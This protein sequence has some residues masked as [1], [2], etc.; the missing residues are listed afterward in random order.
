ME[1]A[2]KL[3]PAVLDVNAVGVPD[4]RLGEAVTLVV[5]PRPGEDLDADDVIAWVKG[6][7]AGYKAPRHVVIVDEV[8]RSGSGKADYR[9]ARQVATDA[10]SAES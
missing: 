5:A 10:V 2:A 9:W 8:R 3:H 6:R 7:L 1:E 4:A